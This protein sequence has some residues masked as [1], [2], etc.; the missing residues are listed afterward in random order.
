[1]FFLFSVNSGQRADHRPDYALLKEIGVAISSHEQCVKLAL[2]LKICDDDLY[3]LDEALFTDTLAY[4]ILLKW[5]TTYE[6][7]A[8]GSVLHAALCDAERQ[9]LA[10]RFEEQLFGRGETFL[11]FL[12][13][14]QLAL[15]LFL[16]SKQEDKVSS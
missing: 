13:L 10:D 1:M 11:V 6:E 16:F 8:T 3:K 9:D 12:F 15:N 4:E 2:D 7:K 14:H 5:M